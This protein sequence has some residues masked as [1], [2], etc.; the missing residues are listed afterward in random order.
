MTGKGIIYNLSLSKKSLDKNSAA[1]IKKADLVSAY[2][3]YSLFFVK[4]EGIYKID[5]EGKSKKVIDKDADW[6]NIIGMW[7]YNGNVYLL[8]S[9][10]GDIY[11]Y[12]V[13]ESGYSAKSS[14][15][16]GEAGSIKGANSFAIDS[17]IYVG[18]D[19]S[20]RKYTAGGR[21]EFSTSWPEKKVKLTKIFTSFDVEKVYGWDKTN[22]TIY[23][24]GKNGTYERQIN[25]SILAKASDF[26][27]FKDAAYVL[28]NEKIYR[29]G[30]D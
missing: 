24:L 30:L 10:K 17:S 15:L 29:I 20:L 1:G 6:E 14:Y 26:V 23:I 11:K 21:D 8:D 22:E 9:G 3:D 16:K 18:L 2:E 27:V 5:S 28:V 12:L 7:I 19:D 4:E 25:S 13:A